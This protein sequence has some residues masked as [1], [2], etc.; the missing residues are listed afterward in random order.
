MDVKDIG[1][2]VQYDKLPSHVSTTHITTDVTGLG[3]YAFVPCLFLSKEALAIKRENMGPSWPVELGEAVVYVAPP[4]DDRPKLLAIADAIRGAGRVDIEEA[5]GMEH[6]YLVVM[7]KTQ[8]E[9]LTRMDVEPVPAP[10]E[11]LV[12]VLRVIEYTGPRAKVEQQVLRSLHGTRDYGNGA[13]TTAV[14]LHEFP[15]KLEAAK[16]PAEQD[17]PRMERLEAGLMAIA[18]LDATTRARNVYRPEAER[19]GNL[20]TAMDIAR[21]ALGLD[22]PP[23]DVPQSPA[24]NVCTCPDPACYVH[25]IPESTAAAEVHDDARPQPESA[26]ATAAEPVRDDDIP[27]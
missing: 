15:E 12:R 9:M 22:T 1:L 20:D 13:A 11:D 6:P 21:E 4:P 18:D 27:F 3:Q 8:V 7:T 24:R 23:P 14:T 10:K 2:V 17:T 16:R 5:L 19:R 25:G 26:T